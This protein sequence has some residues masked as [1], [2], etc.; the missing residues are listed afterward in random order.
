MNAWLF[1]WIARISL[2]PDLAAAGPPKRLF[3]DYKPKPPPSSSAGDGGIQLISKK[4]LPNDF[5]D[6]NTGSIQLVSSRPIDTGYGESRG[7]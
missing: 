4:T 1:V 5:D 2:S 6:G 7:K 3:G